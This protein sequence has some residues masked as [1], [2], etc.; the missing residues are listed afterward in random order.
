MA[1]NDI[2]LPPT[3]LNGL[4]I[5]F[6]GRLKLTAFTQKILHAS[7]IAWFAVQQNEVHPHTESGLL[8]ASQLQASRSQ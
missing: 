8:K 5:V 7:T 3:I 2:A 4:I 1:T 6:F